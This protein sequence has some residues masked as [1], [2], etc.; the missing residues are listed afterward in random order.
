MEHL[1]CEEVFCQGCAEWAMLSAIVFLTVQSEW[2]GSQ[3]SLVGNSILLATAELRGGAK[4]QQA[5]DGWQEAA[6]GC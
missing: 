6:Q 1:H 2:E 4:W 5:L 3:S